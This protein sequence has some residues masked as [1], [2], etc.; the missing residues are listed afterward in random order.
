MLLQVESDGERVPAKLSGAFF[1]AQAPCSAR[2]AG[3]PLRRNGW[4]PSSCPSRTLPTRVCSIRDRTPPLPSILSRPGIPRGD[5]F[6]RHMR[7]PLK[8]SRRKDADA[9]F[10][11][12]K[13]IFVG[14]VGGAAILDD[15]QSAR[16]DLVH[17]AVVEQDDAV[18]NVFFEAMPGQLPV[19]SF[20]GD[21]R[22][23]A[24]VLDPAE[25]PPQFSAQH[26][27]VGKARKQRLYGV[28]HHALGA[29]RVDSKTETD[30]KTLEV[31]FPRL[32][33]FAP[34][35]PDMVDGKFARGDQRLRGRNRARGHWRPDLRRAPRSS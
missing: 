29:D 28:Q 30:E 35:D 4:R 10:V 23:E 24:P 8:R 7:V 14:S 9:V 15:P 1:Q 31:I 6:R 33:D 5:N 27:F 21:D 26:A 16:R 20:S 22:S 25:K 34:L 2:R 3:K 19:A 18:G 12:E 32:L 13:G 11:D 17:D